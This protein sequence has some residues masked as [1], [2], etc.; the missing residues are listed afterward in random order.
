MS[1]LPEVHIRSRNSVN[2]DRSPERA[3]ASFNAL[4]TMSTRSRKITVQESERDPRPAPQGDWRSSSETLD[5]DVAKEES[6]T[7]PMLPLA[8]TNVSSLKYPS[9]PRLRT[10]SS[11]WAANRGIILVILAMFFGAIM[12][13][14][15]RLLELD[16]GH[17]KRMQP[18]LVGR[19]TFCIEN[20]DSIISRYYS[21]V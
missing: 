15:T 7:C 19:S 21:C 2:V 6:E 8:S 16:N 14:V 10:W 18:I 5:S 9:V 20:F 11:F 12:G 1:V 17:H 3:S 4:E 13:L